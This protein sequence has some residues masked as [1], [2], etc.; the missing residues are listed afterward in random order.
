ML[1][2]KSKMQTYVLTKLLYAD[3]MRENAKTKTHMQ[4]A[5]DRV[6][7]TCYNND[8]TIRTK[9]TAVKYQQVSGKPDNEP[10]I[11]MNRQRLQVVNKI[12]LSH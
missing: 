5:M 7:Q 10:T 12:Q 8:L 1:Q 2:A 6:A 4:G 3:D 9:T 11:N